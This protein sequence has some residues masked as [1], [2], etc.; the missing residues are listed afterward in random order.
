VILLKT[1]HIASAVVWLGNFVVTGVWS[2]RALRSSND[3]R[4]FAARE[5]LF[6]DLLFTASFGSAV[7]LTGILLARAESIPLLQT[8]WTRTALAVVA[9]SGVL[10]LSVLLPLE[11]RMKRAARTDDPGFGRLFV[12]WSIIGWAVTLALFAVIYLMV[13]KPA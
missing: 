8:L 3:V 13:S 6:T 9:A 7:T 10:W 1:L 5:I 11:L 4:R 2:M 12:I